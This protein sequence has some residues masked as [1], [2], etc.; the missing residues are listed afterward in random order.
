MGFPPTAPVF[1]SWPTCGSELPWE[2]RQHAGV[3]LTDQNSSS[4]PPVNCSPKPLRVER[5]DPHVAVL[6]RVWD[7]TS[8]LHGNSAK[9][10]RNLK[11]FCIS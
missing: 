10:V 1:Q 8:F 4:V 2:W 7:G 6:E 9:C 11:V 5:A 3:T